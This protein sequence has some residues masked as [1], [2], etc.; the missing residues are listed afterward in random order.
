MSNDEYA[1]PNTG[2][3]PDTVTVTVYGLKTLSKIQA[4][5]DTATAG[6]GLVFDLQAPTLLTAAVSLPLTAGTLPDT[7]LNSI[8]SAIN[9]TGL[10]TT[11]VGDTLVKPLIIAGGGSLTYT[12]TYT[13]SD[14][15]TGG[16]VS[17]LTLADPSAFMRGD[18]PYA[19]YS[20][21]NEI[22]LIDG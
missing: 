8:V 6:T 2:N 3:I 20:F 19:I 1:Y 4:A 13:L 9:A 10:N 7:V 12:A 15:Q 5:L 14:P 22:T 16:T 18:V 11:L 17:S 21:I